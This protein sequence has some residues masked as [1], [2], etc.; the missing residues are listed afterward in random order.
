M[1][2]GIYRIRNLQNNKCYIGSAAASGGINGRWSDHRLDLNKNQHHSKYLQRAWNKYGAENFVFEVL[3]YCDPENC[4]MYEQIAMDYFKPEYNIA[5]I[6]GSQLGY[7][8]TEQGRLN[9]AANREYKIGKDN[10]CF[11]RKHTPETIEFFQNDPRRK[12]NLGK[13][14]SES[15]KSLIS[16]RQMGEY[17][18]R[19]KL[20]FEKVRKIRELRF[21][22]LSQMECAVLFNVSRSTI[23]GIDKNKTWKDN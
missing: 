16:T 10:Q 15:Q 6:A 2:T 20:T 13:N 14:L 22:G 12:T 9:S 8:H 18:S 19:A 21:I 1:K 5:P 11:G 7:R 23:Q 4:L 17:N 3:L